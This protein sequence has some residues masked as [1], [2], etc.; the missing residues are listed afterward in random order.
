M[1]DGRVLREQR[2]TGRAR[3]WNGPGGVHVH[4]HHGTPLLK[5]AGTDLLDKPGAPLDFDVPQSL[6]R[7]NH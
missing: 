3:W 6:R 2:R 5:Y 1:T 4:T 7:A